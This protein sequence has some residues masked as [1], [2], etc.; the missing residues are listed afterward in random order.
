MNPNDIKEK[1]SDKT[2]LI[3][4]NSPQNPTGA[5]ITEEEMRK[6]Y[7]IAKE[8]DVYLLSDE[9][10]KKM[11]FDAPTFSPSVLDKCKERVIMING[12]SKSY[13]MTG[14]R[15]GYAVGPEDVI[16]KMGLLFETISSCVTPFIQRAAIKA[17]DDPNNNVQKMNNV[18]TERR[19]AITDGLNS[20]PGV[21]CK[22]P[23]GAFYV[24]PNIKGTGMTSEEFADF[25]LNECH[26]A[27]SPGTFFGDYGEG[28]VRF[29]YANTVKNIKEAI[30]RL[31]KGLQNRNFD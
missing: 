14:W 7:E 2:R 21:T 13:A 11:S 19:K 29:C 1:I 3:M 23:G 27:I 8:K 20:L 10:Y 4:T 30:E 25:A 31:R 22:V 5:I 12:F 17:F 9:I 24:F 28:Y 15:I 18:L 16:Q 26:V 6:I